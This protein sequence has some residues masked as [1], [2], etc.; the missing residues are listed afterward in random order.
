MVDGVEGSRD[1]DSDLEMLISLLALYTLGCNL[2]A[3]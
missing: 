3:I 1:I 2:Q